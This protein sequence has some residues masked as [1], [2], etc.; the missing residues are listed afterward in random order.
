MLPAI[1]SGPMFSTPDTWAAMNAVPPEATS[2]L[3]KLIGTST[4]P[5]TTVSSTEFG[6]PL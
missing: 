3:L 2:E 1:S 6:V 5:M 4:P